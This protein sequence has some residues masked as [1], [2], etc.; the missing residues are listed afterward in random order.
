MRMSQAG[1]GWAACWL[2]ALIAGLTLPGPASGQQLYAAVGATTDYVVRGLTRTQG[3][4]AVQADAGFVTTRGTSLGAGASTVDL[5]P[6]AG[7]SSEFA[8]HV[9]QRLRINMDMAVDLRLTRYLY[10]G[11][12]DPYPYDY[13][14]M[15]AG[16]VFR[17]VVELAV[18]YSPDWSTFSRTDGFARGRPALWA[19]GSASWPISASTNLTGG[20]GYA[21]VR[22]HTGQA[23]VYYSIGVEWRWRRLTAGLVLVG[24]DATAERLFGPTRADDRI[25]GSVIWKIR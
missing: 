1:N 13:T 17:D 14:E 8:I 20:V 18:A 25:V 12:I 2:A 16:L 6:G 7:A 24:T 10:P 19:E 23:Y 4:A 3:D 15:R 11:D 9:A 5:N 22:E 21:D